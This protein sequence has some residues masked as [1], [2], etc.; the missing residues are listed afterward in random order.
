M[1]LKTLLHIGKIICEVGVIALS[2][3]FLATPTVGVAIAVVVVGTVAWGLSQTKDAM[4]GDSPQTECDHASHKVSDENEMDLAS[5]DDNTDSPIIHIDGHNTDCT[6]VNID[7]VPV[8][9]DHL[10]IISDV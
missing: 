4:K 2:I 10:Y 8:S 5:R 1:K 7:G 9:G 6:I 3:V